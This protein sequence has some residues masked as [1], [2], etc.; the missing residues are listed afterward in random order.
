MFCDNCG[1]QLNDGEKFCPYC[2][3]PVK[4]AEGSE[5]KGF[6]VNDTVQNGG[7]YAG[8]NNA[9]FTYQGGYNFIPLRTDRSLLVYV[10]LTI[11]TCGIY[12]L[13]FIYQLIQDVNMA[14]DGDGDET[15]GF[16]MYF[17]LTLVT[18]GIY[19]YVWYYKL[20]NRLQY[21]CAR[22]GQPTNEDGAAV[23]LWMLLGSLLCGVGVFIGW[24][25]LIK[26]TNT[27]CAG[28]NR[29]HGIMA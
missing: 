4:G 1:T 9:G 8:M 15:P 16:W 27:V 12:S 6:S 22:Y 17:L 21:N 23:L 29:A 20:G 3:A 28:Y 5:V 24:H 10:L 18:C 14:C 19:G 7:A 13:V 25:I 26:N 11:V 2:G